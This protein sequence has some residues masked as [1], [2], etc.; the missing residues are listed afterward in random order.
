MSGNDQIEKITELFISTGKAHHR[1]FIETDGE[2]PDRAI[3]YGK[4]LEEPLA[5]TLTTKLSPG[6]NSERLTSL[7]KKFSS[8]SAPEHWTKIYANALVGAEG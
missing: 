4:Y 1:A 2:D 3:W 6:E 8:L 7:D 5:D